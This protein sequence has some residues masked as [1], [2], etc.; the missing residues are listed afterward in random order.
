V[1]GAGPAPTDHLFERYAH[2]LVAL[3]SARLDARLRSKVDAEDVVQSAL[4]T[5][6]RRAAKGELRT[7]HEG[8]LW[9]LLVRITL[10]KCHAQADHFFA[11]CRDVRR[12]D[13]TG[14]TAR[15]G[16]AEVCAPEPTPDEA[17]ALL[18][19]LERVREGLGTQRKRQVL[20]LTLEGHTVPEISER[21]GY[22]ERGVE[23]AR[24]E[25]SQ[26]LQEMLQ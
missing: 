11:A 4:R 16:P 26:R 24:A 14:E 12:E 20:D 19:L 2:R 3:A 8:G 13:A 17:V 23:R 22:Y 5:F 9:A 15:T 10:C 6:C 18:E 21:I 7:T 1:P 25:A